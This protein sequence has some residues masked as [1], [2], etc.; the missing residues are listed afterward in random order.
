MVGFFIRCGLL[1]KGY[2]VYMDNYYTFSELF[3]ELRVYNIYVCGI[4]RK[5]RKGVLEVIKMK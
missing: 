5:N 1:D 3:E 4:L 2:Y